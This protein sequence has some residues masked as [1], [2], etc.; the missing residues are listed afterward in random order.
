MVL[1][2]NVKF[3]NKDWL[4]RIDDY[5]VQVYFADELNKVSG[6]QIYCSSCYGDTLIDVCKNAVLRANDIYAK[7][8]DYENFQK[9]DGNMDEELNIR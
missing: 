4:V 3:N 6:N 5:L 8:F 9:W 7:S 1:E 2:K